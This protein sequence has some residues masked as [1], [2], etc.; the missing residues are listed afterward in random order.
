MQPTQVFSLTWT[1]PRYSAWFSGDGEIQ[2]KGHT[3]THTPQPLQ[4]SGWTTAIGRS[5]RLS[6]C[7]ISPRVFVIASSGQM[8]PQ[9]PQSMHMAGSMKY[10]FLDSP[11]IAPVGHRFSQALHP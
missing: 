4:L 3:S 5:A 10:T 7:V 9:A 8:T 1:L 11:E 6:T 2:S